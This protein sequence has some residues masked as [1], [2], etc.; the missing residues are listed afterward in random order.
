MGPGGTN[1]RLAGLRRL[2]PDRNP[3]RRAADRVEAVVL[4]MLAAGFLA[5]APLAALAGGSWSAAASRS[6]QRAQAALQPVQAVLV[7][8]APKSAAAMSQ[9]SPEALVEARWTAPD[10]HQRTGRVYAPGGS[11]AGRPVTI[12]TDRSGQVAGYPLQHVD[13]AVRSVLAG[14]L[15]V[16]GLAAALGGLGLLARRLL[17]RWRLA[18]WDVSWAV[19]GPQWTGKR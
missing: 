1:G 19:T 11:R 6:A 16:A 12:W 14:V 10:G 2:L 5:G 9:A 8:S 15:S 13:V 4:M 7:Q 18:D 3:L 17:D